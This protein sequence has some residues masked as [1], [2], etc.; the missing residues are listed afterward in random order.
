[1][2][3][4]QIFIRKLTEIILA[5]LNNE[6]FGVNELAHKSGISRTGLNRKLRKILNKSINQFISEV[7]LQ[8]ALEMLQNESLTASE[9]AY[10]VGFRSPAYF[11]TCFQKFFGYSP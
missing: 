1:M 11:N 3:S 8:K 9:V 6:F 7:R 5:N 2:S 10:K 4:D